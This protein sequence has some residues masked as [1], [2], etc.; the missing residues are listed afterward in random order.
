MA[1]ASNARWTTLDF[2]E[3]CPETVRQIYAYWD[4]KRAGRRMPSRSDLDPAEIVPFLPNLILVDVVAHAPLSLVYRLVGTREVE[5][6]GS[7][8]TNRSVADAFYC[9]SQDAA[10]TN[11]RLAIELRAPIFDN[12]IRDSP[13]SR[14]SDRGSIFLPFS[15]DDDTVNKILVYTAFKEI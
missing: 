3:I 15:A 5:A 14:L 4:G 7:D 9:R 2:L 13:H 12:E 11:Y 10:L 6:R 8:P 1:D